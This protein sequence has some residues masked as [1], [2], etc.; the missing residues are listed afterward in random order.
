MRIP[1]ATDLKTRTGV[2]DKDARL[3]NSYI[4][5]RGDQSVVRKRPIAQ[6]GVSVGTGIAQG[7][8][9]FNG[10]FLMNGDVL[11]P[12]TG[13]GTNWNSGTTYGV[14]DMVSLNFVNYWAINSNTNSQPPNGNWSTTF[15]PPVPSVTPSGLGSVSI[16][17]T[18]TGL[19][20]AENAAGQTGQI[21]LTGY[22]NLGN[23]I[24]VSNP[25]YIAFTA[26]RNSDGANVILIM[27]TSIFNAVAAGLFPL[28]TLAAE[29]VLNS[30]N[31]PLIG[32]TYYVASDLGAFSYFAGYG[33]F[34][35]PELV[36][37]GPHP[38]DGTTRYYALSKAGAITYV[39][40]STTINT[41]L[42]TT[43]R[44]NNIY[45]AGYIDMVNRSTAMNN[46]IGRH[47][48][49]GAAIP[50][51]PN[52]AYDSLYG[53]IA[54]DKFGNMGGHIPITG[55]DWIVYL[56]AGFAYFVGTLNGTVEVVDFSTFDGT[57]GLA[58]TLTKVTAIT[59]GGTY[60]DSRIDS[61]LNVYT[62]YSTAGDNYINSDGTITAAPNIPK[63][64]AGAL[65]RRKYSIK[66]IT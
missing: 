5:T 19:L 30:T 37:Y 33:S 10:L 24:Q 14:G 49:T 45:Y 21:Q 52:V 18:S 63:L 17:F 65:A 53:W 59:G 47:P 28:G 26:T 42:E 32:T 29:V 1:L 34:I 35:Y 55:T 36:V 8:I 25:V 50:T 27:S 15:V 22:S 39:T 31:F 60:N 4:E 44:M 41:W 51:K 6:G 62:S 13:G 7:G 3:K 46:V 66:G 38:T 56:K 48:I 12:Y 57:N 58:I 20:T 9:N 2:P 11:S 23:P 40:D 61:V 43:E 16:F 64:T 54:V